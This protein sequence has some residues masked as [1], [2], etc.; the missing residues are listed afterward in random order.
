MTY[1]PT[2][3]QTTDIL[4]KALFK[5]MFERMVDKLGI[6]VLLG[7]RGSVDVYFLFST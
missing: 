1:V 4:T 3:Q 6:F 5:P 2:T 7:L